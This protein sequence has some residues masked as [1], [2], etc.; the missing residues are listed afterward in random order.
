MKRFGRFA[1]AA[2]IIG[3]CHVGPV[4]AH[5]SHATLDP[6]D[7]RTLTGTVTRYGWQMPHVFLKVMAPNPEGK[8][9]EYSIEMGNPPSMARAGWGKDTL[10]EG[11]VITWQGS[12]DRNKSRAYSSLSW[13]EVNGLRIG[14]DDKV[15][16]S[17]VAPSTDFSGVWT[18]NDPGGFKPNYLPPTDW[19]YTPFAKALVDAFD[20]SS[21]PA[22]DCY[23]P[24]PPKSTILPYPHIISRPDANT[25][26][27]E[28]D[29]LPTPRVVHL[30]RSHPAGAPSTMGHSVGW[31][32][33]DVLVV[34]TDNFLADRWGSHT[35]VDSSDQKH[36]LEKYTLTDGG[37][38][39]MA[40]ITLT[41]PVYLSQPVTFKHYWAKLPDRELVQAPCTLESSQLWIEGG[42]TK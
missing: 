10:K 37:M 23:D 21:N 13:V 27:I 9:V 32:E 16:V 4:V 22:L 14:T 24:G 12:H 1:S 28:R 30:D 3:L 18:R 40:E 5:H 38:G 31:F 19:P 8:M 17:T 20:E 42:Y 26:L 34:E 11:D 35:G 25:V 2:T 39:L 41:D 15:E 36:L 7:I 33:G 6:N 29:M